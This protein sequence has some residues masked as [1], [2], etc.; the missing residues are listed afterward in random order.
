MLTRLAATA[1][2]SVLLI[3]SA[4]VRRVYGQEC[5][6]SAGFVRLSGSDTLIIEST[7]REGARVSGE[8]LLVPD[9]ARVWY[10]ADLTQYP[11]VTRLALS[12]WRQGT[13]YR[14]PPDQS[15]MLVLGGDSAVFY[16]KR[17][18]SLQVQRNV[19]PIGALPGFHLAEGLVEVVTRQARATKRPAVELP[20]FFVATEGWAPVAHV[21]FVGADSALFYLAESHERVRVDAVGRILGSISEASSTSSDAV[22]VHRI[23]CTA[24]DSLL[25]R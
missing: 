17:G 15:G 9:G 11:R 13:S 16:A 7:R 23:T 18:D 1:W 4:G 5:L 19:A 6:D 10:L 3:P 20:V 21:T 2:L 8:M 25:R 12:L 14:G 24:A 22:R